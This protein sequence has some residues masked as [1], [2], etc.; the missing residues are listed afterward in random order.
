MAA[1][2][3]KLTPWEQEH[4]IG[5]NGDTP[6]RRAPVAPNRSIE[7]AKI[8]IE[9]DKR[10]HKLNPETVE[11]LVGNIKNIG[12]LEPVTVTPHINGEAFGYRLIGGHHRIEAAKRLGWTEIPAQVKPYFHPDE[13]TFAECSDNLMRSDLTEIERKL[14][15]AK[16]DE[17]FRRLYAPEIKAAIKAARVQAADARWHPQPIENVETSAK[18]AAP[19]KASEPAPKPKP[20][21]VVQLAERVTGVPHDQLRRSSVMV[22]KIAGIES[23]IGTPLDNRDELRAQEKLED[24]APEIA[25][26]VKAQAIAG[27]PVSARAKYAEF[28]CSDLNTLLD[29]AATSFIYQVKHAT[30]KEQAVIRSMLDKM[31]VDVRRQQEAERSVK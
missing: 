5:L 31:W 10:Y 1:K 20:E 26:E 12:L 25:K 11:K 19:I 28:K 2:T 24:E 14:H 3:N 29:R 17:L 22:E 8:A 23:L 9:P 7:I 13:A 15:E 6:V 18:A 21:T 16:I 30:V 4:G 27:E